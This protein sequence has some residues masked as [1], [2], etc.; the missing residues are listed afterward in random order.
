MRRHHA[1]LNSILRYGVPVAR[2]V[3]TIPMVKR[4]CPARRYRLQRQGRRE[5]VG[6]R[7][8]TI[9]QQ[10]RKLH[11][12]QRSVVVRGGGELAWSRR[13]GLARAGMRMSPASWPVITRVA[14]AH[15]PTVLKGSH[16]VNMNRQLCA[17]DSSE[18]GGVRMSSGGRSKLHSW[19]QSALQSAG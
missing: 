7:Y 10:L 17:G 18:R 4:Y 6:R 14:L 11:P 9:S 1:R 19:E 16:R 12:P 5:D 8:E 2:D 3:T 13:A 15:M